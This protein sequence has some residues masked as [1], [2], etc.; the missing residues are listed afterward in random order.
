MLKLVLIL[1]TALCFEAAGVIF[2]SKGLK[3]LP[4]PSSYLPA[5]LMKLA[6][7]G[8]A[9]PHLLLGVF[10]EAIFF[11]ALLYLI[12]RAD[13]SFVWPLTSLGFV[14]TTIAARVYLGE[15]VS[16]VRWTGVVLILCG[17]ALITYSEKVKKAPMSPAAS[18]QGAGLQD[19][20]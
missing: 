18:A 14:F 5:E 8:A 12:S 9:N 17:A 4:P 19:S 2:L 13:V 15:N 20:R 6:A 11:G 16:N 7:R 1:I 3:Q 10:F